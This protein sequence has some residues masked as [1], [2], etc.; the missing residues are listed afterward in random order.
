MMLFSRPRARLLALVAVALVLWLLRDKFIADPVARPLTRGGN[1]A[2]TVARPGVPSLDDL[3]VVPQAL[4]QR[5]VLLARTDVNPFVEAPIFVPQRAAK[6]EPPAEPAS[7]A[8]PPPP[9]PPKLPYRFYGVFNE[10]GQA[11][12][13]FLGLG[14]ALIHARAGDTLEG[15]F[16]LDSITRRE[17]TFV[18]VQQNLTLRMPI[19]GEPS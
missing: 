2:S 4:P 5:P 7:A 10:P 18:H 14:G 1:A 13:V 17:L 3:C 6:A 11:P 9:P 8:P 12:M 19:D 15:G 16:R